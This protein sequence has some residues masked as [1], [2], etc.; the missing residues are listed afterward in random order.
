MRARRILLAEDD[1]D[2]RDIV[3]T[4]LRREGYEVLEAGDAQQLVMRLVR[5]PAGVTGAAPSID[6]I[7]T[8][9]R[10]PGCSGLDVI[11]ALREAEWQTPMIVMTAFPDAE[12]RSRAKA[13][14]AVMLD[15][16]FRMDVLVTTVRNSLR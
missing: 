5:E 3:A 2:M 13:L 4:A 6:L 14:G 1:P 7:L 10:M 8:D 12:V 15:K 16:P 9:V 11:D